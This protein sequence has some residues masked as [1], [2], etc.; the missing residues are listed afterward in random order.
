MPYQ[1][2]STDWLAACTLGVGMHWT[3]QTAPRTGR[4]AD[5]QT[6]VARFDLPAFLD[7]VHASG[8][9]YVIFTVT[10][11]LQTLPCPH[12]VVDAILP[13]RTAERDLLGELAAGLAQRGKKLILYYNHA[14]N[15]GADPAWERAVGYHDAV[16]GRLGDNLCH[17]VQWLSERYGG[18]FHGWWFDSCSA[19]DPRGTRNA[20]TT[21]M[22]G[23]QF[24]WEQLTKAA[25]S[26]PGSFGSS[27]SGNSG[28][29]GILVAYNAGVA[30]TF[31]YTDHQD[32]WAGE[33]KTLPI[34]PTD[35]YL[36]TGLQWHGWTCLEDRR[37]L[38]AD[39]AAPPPRP[40]YTDE[41]LLTF[42]TACR[43]C[44]APMSFNVLCYQDGSL[45]ETSVEQLGRVTQA[46]KRAGVAAT[47][48]SWPR[49]GTK[50]T[51]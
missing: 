15:H 38:Y 29:P 49:K 2:A 25:K 10:H 51:E 41:E 31:L 46:M 44:H 45:A 43:R 20:V 13:G 17:I 35:R 26:H 7:G 28:I 39:N 33:L 6:A 4:A 1:R 50:A 8:A 5:F 9:D 11:A 30:Q 14:C 48:S 24:P 3:A 18:Q 32:Y 19:L 16:K 36:P 21:D 12:P 22:N 27:A 23:Y 34:P 37:W 47:Q 42:L 40:L